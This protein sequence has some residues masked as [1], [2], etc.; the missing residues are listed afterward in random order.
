SIMSVSSLVK[1]VKGFYQI[2][3][4]K[5]FRRTPGV[6]F[7]MITK[8]NIFKIDAIDRVIHVSDAIS[9]G[10]VSNVEYPWYMHP[11]QEDHLLV[12]Q[13]ERNVELFSPETK[14]IHRFRCTPDE[15]YLNDE[16]VFQ[17]G[18]LLCWSCGI[19]HHVKSGVNGSASIN[20]A[21][22]YPGFHIDTNFHI[23]NLDLNTGEYQVIR[24][25]IKDQF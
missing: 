6:A 24:E 12:L 21:T 2:L 8:R 3:A 9:P 7:E 1:E 11:H 14:E 18:N 10:K 5:A 13:G 19:F 16:L 15:I 23:Y 17:G 25:G 20:L 4:L 22:H